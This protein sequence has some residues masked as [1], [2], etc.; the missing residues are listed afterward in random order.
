MDE[1]GADTSDQVMQKLRAHFND[2]PNAA[3]SFGQGMGRAMAGGSDIDLVLSIDDIDEGLKA[4]QEIADIL[5]A[6]ASELTEVSIDMTEGLPQVELILTG[7]GPITWGFRSAG[8]PMKYP[9]P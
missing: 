8:L 7:G 1:P 4:A 9:P 5:K 2:F 3:L 6:E